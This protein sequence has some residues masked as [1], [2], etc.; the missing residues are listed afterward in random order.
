M[1]TNVTKNKFVDAWIAE[2]VEL[3]KPD[4]IVLIGSQS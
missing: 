4:N 3:V 1:N 2:M